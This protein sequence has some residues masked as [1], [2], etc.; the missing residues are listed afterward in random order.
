M[1]FCRLPWSREFF[2]IKV[3]DSGIGIPEEYQE[4][5]FERFFRADA[6]RTKPGNGLG[7]SMVHAIVLAHGATIAVSD[8]AG[9]GT[10]FTIRFRLPG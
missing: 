8:T 7:L 3:A 9:G 6:S 1:S 10:T 2:Y 5:I 4:H